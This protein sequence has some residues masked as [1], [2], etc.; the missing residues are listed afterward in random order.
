MSGAVDLS[1]LA[2]KAEAA[3]RAPTRPPGGGA[4]GAAGPVVVDVTDASFETEVIGR[5]SQQLVIVELWAA[6]SP[7]SQQ[8]SPLLEALAERAG[9]EWVLARVDVDASP[10]IAQA[11]GVQSVPMVVALAAGQPVAAFNGP[12]PAAQVQGWIDEVLAKV[13]GVLTGAPGGAPE[14]EQDP[15]MAA[16]EQLLNDGDVDG[17]LAL[18][19]Q[20]AESD[21]NDVEAASTVR[22]LEFI[23]RAQGHDPSIIDTAAPGDL[24][25]QLAAADVLLLS[26]QPEAAF[27]RVLAAVRGFTGDDKDRARKRLLELFELFEPT[28][29]M[30]AAARRKLA[31]ALY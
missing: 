31:A 23:V 11:F 12:Q 17:A 1:G 9:G 13:G 26:Q 21:P 27:D 18:Y 7:E 25:A 28:D 16:A 6:W 3:R 8:F 15:R 4:P 29:P 20:V 24:D 19:R 2:A 30:V 5:S 22:N 14:P 10:G